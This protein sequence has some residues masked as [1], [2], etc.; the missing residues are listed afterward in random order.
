MKLLL[1]LSLFFPMVLPFVA[2]GKGGNVTVTED[3]DNIPVT[4][5][6]LF[7]SRENFPDVALNPSEKYNSFSEDETASKILVIV[8]ADQYSTL[9][10]SLSQYS[11]DLESEGYEVVISTVANNG[12]PVQLKSFIQSQNATS[13]LC[14]VV[15]VGNLQIPW[16]ETTEIWESV[17][18]EFPC[19]LYF[20][21]VDGIWDDSDHDGVFDSHSGNNEPDIWV[22]RIS[23]RWLSGD[24]E[25]G[26]L[27]RYFARVHAYRQGDLRLPDR[28]LSIMNKDWSDIFYEDV[29]IAYDDNTVLN[30]PISA[31]TADAYRSLIRSSA[32]EGYESLFIAAHSNASSHYFF[33]GIFQSDEIG[34]INPRASF[35]NLYACSAGRHV[36]YDSLSASYLF[37]SDYVLSVIGSSKTGGMLDDDQFYTRISEGRSMGESFKLWFLFSDK[38]DEYSESWF[39]GMTFLGD[40]TLRISRFMP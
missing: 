5:Y 17:H 25:T 3:P 15:L 2:C 32:G 39:Y 33:S 4:T 6:S 13:P 11:S 12:K 19:D 37:K 18:A 16:F 14:G 23:A 28:A 38:A 31:V 10:A 24:T 27:N 1:L 21:D 9:S 30:S 8:N 20:M 22:G 35:L 36:E 7:A 29:S 26:F 34:V 40:P